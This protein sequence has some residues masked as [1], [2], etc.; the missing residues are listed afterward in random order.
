MLGPTHAFAE[1]RALSADVAALFAGSHAAIYLP[2]AVSKDEEQVYYDELV[3]VQLVLQLPSVPSKL[4]SP[5]HADGAWVEDFS[6]C[7]QLPPLLLTMLDSL[8]VKISGTLASKPLFAKQWMRSG[9]PSAFVLL[10]KMHGAPYDDDVRVPFGKD[11]FQHGVTYETEAKAWKVAWVGDVVAPLPSMQPGIASL[12]LTSSFA[13]NIDMAQLVREIDAPP[14]Q[15]P[16][17]F[18]TSTYHPFMH[19]HDPYIVDVDLLH[20]LTEP[21]T[22]PDETHDQRH[23]HIASKLCMLPVSMLLPAAGIDLV[24]PSSQSLS[25]ER[26]FARAKEIEAAAVAADADIALAPFASDRA[27]SKNN[28]MERRGSLPTAFSD[29]TEAHVAN[30]VASAACMGILVLTRKTS[31]ARDVFPTITVHMRTMNHAAMIQPE[32]PGYA[33]APCSVLLSIELESV[34]ARSTFIVHDL[35]VAVGAALGGESNT[36]LKEDLFRAVVTP[37][38]TPKHHTQFPA[39]ME[40]LA[41][42]NF[43]YTVHLET[44]ENHAGD[45]ARV[46]QH[47]APH[48]TTTVMLRGA[49]LPHTADVDEARGSS[50]SMQWNGTMD[51]SHVRVELQRRLAASIAVLRST[52][53][54]PA[55]PALPVHRIEEQA[56]VVLGDAQHSATALLLQHRPPPLL[57]SIAPYS[58]PVPAAVSPPPPTPPAGHSVSYLDAAQARFAQMTRGESEYVRPSAVHHSYAWGRESKDADALL[59]SSLAHTLI[60]SVEVLAGVVGDSYTLLPTNGQGELGATLS[61]ARRNSVRIRLGVY[62]VSSD[63]MDVVLNWQPASLRA[64]SSVCG[65]VPDRSDVHIGPILPGAS[66]VAELG[67][68]AIASGLQQLGELAVRDT[69]S[70]SS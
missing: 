54:D 11:A 8:Q 49:S 19:T 69:H 1:A 35:S 55:L 39:K 25:L 27:R 46:L 34:C 67:L 31:I 63:V 47:W 48:R 68:C 59:S 18:T 66:R 4:P 6:G 30:D 10:D 53:W 16:F 14:L 15:T 28:A 24:T 38:G 42:Y 2:P 65:F 12:Q 26:A 44:P 52:G 45:V 9:S 41:Q 3:R 70:H 43:L 40:P 21:V 51:L 36:C 23:A 64:A 17:H 61:V 37:L 50:C 58:A 62:N 5:E 56:H 13:L 33:V 29:D 60:A 32:C 22:L 7:A 20:P 57:P